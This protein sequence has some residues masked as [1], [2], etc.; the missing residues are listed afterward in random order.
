VKNI[1]E[2]SSTSCTNNNQE[3][4]NKNTMATPAIPVEDNFVPLPAYPKSLE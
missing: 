3:N 1:V 4:D 2:R